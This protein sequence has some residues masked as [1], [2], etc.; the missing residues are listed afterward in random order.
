MAFIYQKNSNADPFQID[1]IIISFKGAFAKIN[2]LVKPSTGIW[3]N[4][5]KNTYLERA[6]KAS[7]TNICRTCPNE[8]QKK[9]LLSDFTEESYLLYDKKNQPNKRIIYN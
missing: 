3:N 1:D 8:L 9:K 5:K 2:N 6:V 4:N 7:S